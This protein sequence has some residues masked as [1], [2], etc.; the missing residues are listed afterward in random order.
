MYVVGHRGAAA[1]LPENTV[2]GF[3]YA[4]DLGVA[5]VE[6]DVHLTS[7][8]HLIV[9]H[10]A[11]VDRTTISSGPIRELSFETIRGLDAG[12]GE[13]VPTLSEVLAVSKGKVT[14]LC[15]LKGEGTEHPAVDA[16]KEQGMSDEVV[17]TSF[18]TDRI[19]TVR[20]VFKL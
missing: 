19:Q 2:K 12:D 13:Q 14:L 18:H 9:M 10:D 1:V 4:I 6:C 11:T 5:F 16:V 20:I 3:Q 17:F 8:N 15:E 7:D